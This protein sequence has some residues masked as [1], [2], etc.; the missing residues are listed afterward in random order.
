MAVGLHVYDYYLA[1]EK[2]RTLDQV[3]MQHVLKVLADPTRYG[4]MKCIEKGMT[5][6]KEIAKIFSISPSGVT[7]QTKFL[8]ENQ[9]LLIDPETKRYV[10]NQEIIRLALHTVLAELNIAPDQIASQT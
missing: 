2:Q 8:L 4:I 1:L 5:S 7:Y 3:T 9:I 10:L 6:N